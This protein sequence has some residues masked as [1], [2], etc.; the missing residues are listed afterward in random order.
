M[1]ATKT[2]QKVQNHRKMLN[3]MFYFH[4]LSAQHIK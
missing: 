4:F 3:H 2:P 1:Y